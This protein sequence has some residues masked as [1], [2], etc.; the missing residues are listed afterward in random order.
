MIISFGD[1]TTEDIFHGRQSP[2]TKKLSK[3]LIDAI[4]LKL[5]MLNAAHSLIDLRSPPGNRLEALQGERKGFYSI[6]VNQQWRIVFHFSD[7]N[8]SSVRLI[9]YH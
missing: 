3:L 7:A 8:A 2:H 1:K 5:D 9:D 6:R 4:S